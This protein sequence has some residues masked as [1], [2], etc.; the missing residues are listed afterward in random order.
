MIKPYP[1]QVAILWAMSG[2]IDK[3]LAIGSDIL[4]PAM[5]YTIVN[6]RAKAN[7]CCPTTIFFMKTD[8]ELTFKILC[9]FSTYDEV[10]FIPGHK[11]VTVKA[12]R[13]NRLTETADSG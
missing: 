11:K 13:I 8:P 7:G 6:L 12:G 1:C 4:A 2:R 5:R 10:G 9:L 3:I